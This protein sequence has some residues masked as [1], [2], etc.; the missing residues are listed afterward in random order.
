MCSV[1]TAE[2]IENGAN[3]KVSAWSTLDVESDKLGLR[4]NYK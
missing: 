4:E 3:Q 2:S 1:A